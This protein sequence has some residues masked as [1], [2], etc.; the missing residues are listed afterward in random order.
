MPGVR[1]DDG[2]GGV[3]TDH[4]HRVYVDLREFLQGGGVLSE[5]GRGGIA[6]AV[7]GGGVGEEGRDGERDC[8]GRVPD[9]VEPGHYSGHAARGRADYAYADGAVWRGGRSGWGGGIS[10]FGGGV[11]CNRAGDC[12]GWWIFGERGES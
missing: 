2:A 11:V 6:D 5:Q 4:Q 7:V 9:A 3:R 8:A 1:R 12:G 10:G